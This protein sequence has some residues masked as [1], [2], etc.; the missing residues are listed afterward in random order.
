[1]K[2]FPSSGLI[3]VTLYNSEIMCFDSETTNYSGIVVPHDSLSELQLTFL[4][5]SMRELRE[6]YY[7]HSHI[8]QLR[9]DTEEDIKVLRLICDHSDSRKR[10]EHLRQFVY[11]RQ[12]GIY[13][14]EWMAQQ[15]LSSTLQS[16]F[17][18]DKGGNWFANA[19]LEKFNL[20]ICECTI[21]PYTLEN[22]HVLTAKYPNIE[23]HGGIL[24]VFMR[25]SQEEQSEIVHSYTAAQV[26]A[27][28]DYEWYAYRTNLEPLHLE[29]V[30]NG[31]PIVNY[32]FVIK[33]DSKTKSCNLKIRAH[34]MTLDEAEDFQSIL[35]RT[36]FVV[37]EYIYMSSRQIGSFIYLYLTLGST[38]F[39]ELLR[40]SR[41]Y[42]I[43]H[44]GNNS[45]IEAICYSG[46]LQESIIALSKQDC[47]LPLSLRLE[48]SDL[49]FAPYI[50]TMDSSS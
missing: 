8:P 12:H 46:K 50:D 48:L 24:R 21:N 37:P 6:L 16:P 45:A 13:V 38:N 31:F 44:E 36:Q 19:L 2:G 23:M 15:S 41:D 28:V 34:A 20:K 11:L 39:E 49:D 1:M 43:N 9:F 18:V 14:S 33:T 27:V 29:R 3:L 7:Y 22:L 5:D 47:E 17:M 32:P 40:Y 25:L 26:E 30:K 42:R 4:R 10:L 35:D